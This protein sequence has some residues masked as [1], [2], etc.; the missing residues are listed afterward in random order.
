MRYII[1]LPFYK[2]FSHGLTMCFTVVGKKGVIYCLTFE[3]IYV[4]DFSW[5]L[6]FSHKYLAIFTSF[7][8]NFLYIFGRSSTIIW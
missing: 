7:L 5:V 3:A 2:L 1:P 4:H 8:N 6:F